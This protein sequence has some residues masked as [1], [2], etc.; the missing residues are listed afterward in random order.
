MKERQQSGTWRGAWPG[1]LRQ[2]SLDLATVTVPG[3]LHS[4][5]DSLGIDY[6]IVYP[7]LGLLVFLEE[8]AEPRRT[9]GSNLQP[10][11]PAK[12]PR[13]L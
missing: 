11:I 5:L 7:S 9:D 13:R 6:Q 12:V 10:M 4:R 1:I 8:D 2:N 3:L